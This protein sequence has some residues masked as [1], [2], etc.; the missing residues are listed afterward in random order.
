VI[1]PN[2][3]DA[4]AV[5]REEGRRAAARGITSGAENP[6]TRL[7]RAWD[8]GNDEVCAHQKAGK[9]RGGHVG[10]VPHPCR[11]FSM[12]IPAVCNCC[13]GCAKGC[14][15]GKRERLGAVASR[16]LHKL[17]MRRTP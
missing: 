12:A 2:E 14:A 4:E 8:E 7:Q 17:G 10:S 13:D 11:A 9:D 15:I 16:V 5:A 1:D 3:S 6:Y